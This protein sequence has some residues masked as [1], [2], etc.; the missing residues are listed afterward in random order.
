MQD[1]SQQRFL[2]VDDFTDF[3]SSVK[4]M[5]REMGAR[6]VDTANR[7]EE[8]IAMC[9]QKRYDIILHD[10]NLGAGKNGQQV[11]EELIAA[12]LI[13]HLCI[14]IM[15]TAESSQ[16]MVLSALEHEPDAYLTKPFNRAS[17]AQRL[18]KL[19]ERKALLKPVLQALDKQAPAE[20]LAACDRLSQQ[21][22]RLLPLCQ[23]YK[24][25]ALRTLGRSEELER[26]LNAVLAER[27]IP[28]AYQALG[29]QL[30]ARGEHLHARQLYEK[31]LQTFPMQP[32]LYDGL[33]AVL[34][35]QGET[36]RAQEILEDAV[37]LSPLA[38]RRQSQLGK[39]AMHNEDF[40]GA[41]KAFRSAV[42]QG[43]NS[44]FK[45]AE[46]YLSLSQ[47][48]ISGAGEETLDKRAQAEINQTLAELDNQFGQDK[49]LQVRARLMQA[50]SL[51]KSGDAAR[52][53][54][55]AAQ[56]VAD[57]AQLGEFFC[58]DAALAVANQLK[59]LGQAEAG[60]DVLKSCVEIYGD[61]PAV[62]QG[63]ARLTS[64]PAILSGAKEAVELNRQG[65]RAYQLS[66]FADALELFRRALVLQPKNI[67]IALNTAQSL[68]RLSGEQAS[69]TLTEEC[70]ACLDAV[71]MIPHDDARYERYQQ[72][73]RRAFDE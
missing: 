62:L 39:L 65:V 42:E 25:G 61:D 18:D 56:A 4:A 6:D 66:R 48:L 41:S 8:A 23:R 13:S 71:R 67:S 27:A 50:S 43:K 73:R 22:K 38:I 5:L 3:L 37:R 69:A 51:H 20:V 63:V 49:V 72:L 46:N 70:R 11:L 58:A 9:R 17:L 35:A 33:A 2:I 32:G 10:Y 21:D 68:Q 52:A 12:R 60:E 55:L 57:M 7:G 15:V 29:A 16:A 26:L 19:M 24:A 28:W 53:K 45:S 31:A 1:Y 47:A 40:A 34:D 14:F 64:D 54:Q 44:R 59:Q 36:K 30:L